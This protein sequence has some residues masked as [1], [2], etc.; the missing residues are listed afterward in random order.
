[1]KS[2][3]VICEGNICR[4]PMAEGLLREALPGVELRSAGLGALVGMP[5]DP[6]CVRLLADRG[7]DIRGHRA[8]QVTRSDC[9]RADLILVMDT[10]QKQRLSN[11]YPEVRGRVFRIAERA[12]ADVEDP[13]RRPEPVFHAVLTKLESNVDEWQRVLRRC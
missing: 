6:I 8:S 12:A 1:M 13:Y 11:L 3:L 7:I 5:A 4:S 9:L 10:E 2:I